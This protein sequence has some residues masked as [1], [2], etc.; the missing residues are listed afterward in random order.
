MIL[1][2]GGTGLIGRHVVQ[3]LV[4]EGWPVRCLLPENR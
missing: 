1:V 2:T 4:A 3:R